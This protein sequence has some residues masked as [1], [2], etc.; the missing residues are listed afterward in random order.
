MSWSVIRIVYRVI[1]LLVSGRFLQNL[2]L[3][4]FVCV[5]RDGYLDVV[6]SVHYGVP[7]NCCNIPRAFL[8]LEVIVWRFKSSG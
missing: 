4:V 5:E 1:S 3:R 8:G 6:V 2:V 7:R